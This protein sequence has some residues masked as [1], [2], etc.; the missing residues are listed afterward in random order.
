[1]S[2]ITLA[3]ALEWCNE[4]ETYFT[5]NAANDGL[6]LTSSSGGPVTID[7]TDGT[8][9]GSALATALQSAMNANTTLTGTG[10]ITF[11]VSYSSTTRKFTIS[12]GTGKTIA[13]T[14]TGS[15]AGL[16]FGFNQNHA[17]AVS[18]T[19]DIPAGDSAGRVEKILDMADGWA[20]RSF[21]FQTIEAGEYIEYHNGGSPIIFLSETPVITLRR[22]TCSTRDGISL[23]NSNT[24]MAYATV[25]VDS[26]AV[27]LTVVG[28]SNAGTST[29]DFAT[30]DDL[31]EIATAI[32]ALGTGWTAALSDA[33]F[34]DYPYTELIQ[35]PGIQM[36]EG[37]TYYLQIPDNDEP[38]YI[39]DPDKGQLHAGISINEI[40]M[41]GQYQTE[42]NCWPLGI[43]N[44]RVEFRGGYE[45]VPAQI[46]TAIGMLVKAIY[47][48]DQ[49][50]ASGASN[51]TTSGIS[52]VYE[53]LPPDVKKGLASY[54]RESNTIW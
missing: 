28:G 37:S 24:D 1:M 8:Y 51:W 35:T 5:I 42:D 29:V 38:G 12:A 19:S 46:Q 44:V 33:T 34:T 32:N 50:D 3:D 14:N 54:R 41:N 10:S 18:I 25:K 17:A 26:T 52:K 48:R 49:E 6:V 39:L 9:E 15:D 20:K 16:T 7:I 40:G 43:R 13:Y 45:T 36:Y 11:A 22:V 31:G 27:S 47:Q 21:L 4:V 30:Y 2:L 23:V 53:S